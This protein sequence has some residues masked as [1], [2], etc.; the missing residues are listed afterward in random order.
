MQVY[1]GRGWE[2]AENHILY[3]LGHQSLLLKDHYTAASLFNELVATTNAGPGTINPLQ[4]MCHL[5]EFFIVHH[6]REKEDKATATITIPFFKAQ[7][8]LL[9]LNSGSSEAYESLVTQVI[10]HSW[11]DLEKIITENIY[12]GE[13]LH[14]S[15]TCQNIYGPQSSNLLTPEV[16]VNETIRLLLPVSN[17]FQTPLL[18]RKLRLIWKFTKDEKSVF[19]NEDSASDLVKSQFIDNVKVEQNGPLVLDLQLTPLTSGELNIHGIEY[20][21]KAVFPQSESTDYT[22]KGKQPLKV[23]GP[24]LNSSK[25]HKVSKTPLYTKDSRLT[26]KVVEN[27]PKLSVVLNFPETLVQGEITCMDLHLQNDGNAPMSKI[28]LVHDSP[29]LLSFDNDGNSGN[30]S[31]LFDQPLINPPAKLDALGAEILEESNKKLDILNVP[32]DAELA[33]GCAVKR[34]LWICAQDAKSNYSLYFSYGNLKAKKPL[35][36]LLKRNYKLKIL[37]SVNVK[38]VQV[39]ACMYDDDKSQG[40]LV[41][42]TNTSSDQAYV[43]QVSMLSKSSRILSGII[44]SNE[45][46]PVNQG[47]TNVLGLQTRNS[48][49]DSNS[50]LE[51]VHF[52]TLNCSNSMQKLNVA[53]YVNF[54]KNAFDFSAPKE[55]VQLKSDYV[56]VLWQTSQHRSG[57]SL[58]KITEE[59]VSNSNPDE[60]DNDTESVEE[61]LAL[62]PA[63]KKSC[64]VRVLVDET[65]IKHDFED[66]PVCLVPFQVQ[67]DNFLPTDSVFRY[68]TVEN[69]FNSVGKFLGCTRA[70]IPMTGQSKE[71]LRFHV[72][73]SN[74]GLFS[75][76]GLSFQMTERNEECDDDEYIPLEVNFL[77]EE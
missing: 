58:A 32:L 25:E 11:Q 48:D 20:M 36:R 18:M 53:P 72:A 70:A 64:R 55:G 34:K 62:I 76:A 7:D 1:K 41:H 54:L 30:S 23:Q 77:V 13:F 65:N 47:E 5:R 42:L 16:A 28:Y 68:K 56:V 61:T 60:V 44:S 49:S 39:N 43:K 8:C 51:G 52:S 12:G 50:T 38:A 31:Q 66:N 15:Q 19:S 40:L 67:I 46:S 22:I 27:Q 45:N 57:L 29:G 33:P 4:Q 3:T 24:R 9:D 6:M 71:T 10:G 75:Y 14:L 17:P 74:P 73:V 2:L 26:I 21:L 37:P 59:S 63:L 69:D 35:M